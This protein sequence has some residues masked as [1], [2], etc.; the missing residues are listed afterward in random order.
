MGM[1]V[2][3]SHLNDPGFYE[4]ADMMK[5]PFIASHSNAGRSAARPE[6]EDDQ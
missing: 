1:V 5:M 6:P 4:V 2:D 3:V